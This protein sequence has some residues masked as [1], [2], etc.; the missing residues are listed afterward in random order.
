MKE[1]VSFSIMAGSRWNGVEGW[2]EAPMGTT[3]REIC[4]LLEVKHL[5]Q[6]DW[7]DGRG[8]R[9]DP[10]QEIKSGC[11]MIDYRKRSNFSNLSQYILEGVKK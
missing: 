2:F 7:L 10:S 9:I 6:Y 8:E 3:V 4:D 5:D 1:T 11:Y